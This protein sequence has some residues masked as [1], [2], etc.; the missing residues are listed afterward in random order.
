METLGDA[1]ECSH[2]YNGCMVA[3]GISDI[4]V[5]PVSATPLSADICS[6]VSNL[7][8]ER[9]LTLFHLYG[10]NVRICF[11]ILKEPTQEETHLRHVQVAATKFARDF[12]KSFQELLE[13][14]FGSR[15]VSSKIFMLRPKNLGSRHSPVLT[16]PTTFLL[17]A[18]TL[19]LSRDVA[20]QQDVVFAML[21]SH[22]TLR[23]PAGWMFENMAHVVAA[24]PARSSLQIYTSTKRDFIPAPKVMIS[25]ND[26]MGHIHAPFYWRPRETNFEGIDAVIRYGNSVWA[27]QYTVSRA[28]RAA[29]N[30]LTEV[31]NIMNWNRDVKWYL[32]MVGSTRWEAESA[33]NSQR[34]TGKWASIPVYACVM[35]IGMFDEQKLQQL[36]DLLDDVSTQ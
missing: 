31:H 32:V 9:G 2:V 25:G 13:L 21:N 7:H 17:K 20:T 28:H 23:S 3:G 16:I 36:G 22:P 33:R 15:D 14:D 29:T 4:A 18:L 6:I 27:L 5:C 19:A 1:A 11:H 34:L 8:V 24:D 10:P 35:Q 12:S 30:G 26:A